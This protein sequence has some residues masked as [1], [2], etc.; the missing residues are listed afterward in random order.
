MLRYLT[1]WTLPHPSHRCCVAAERG[2]CK[3]ENR[4]LATR[5]FYDRLA[6]KA[7]VMGGPHTIRHTVRTWLA[8]GGVADAEADV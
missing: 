1:V 2:V 3:R 4:E 5:E 7:S 8:E 6:E